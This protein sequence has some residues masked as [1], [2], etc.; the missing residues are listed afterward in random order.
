M[1]ARTGDS[2]SVT[3]ASDPTGRQ[4]RVLRVPARK[5]R[6]PSCC[7]RTDIWCSVFSQRT[8]GRSSM[9]AGR[10]PASA[11]PVPVENPTRPVAS[12]YGTSCGLGS[13]PQSRASIQ[14]G[15]APSRANVAL[16]TPMEAARGLGD[17]GT[18]VAEVAT[19]PGGRS[20]GGATYSASTRW[21]PATVSTSTW[22]RRSRRIEPIRHHQR[23]C[24]CVEPPGRR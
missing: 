13:V 16:S 12:A 2:R 9:Q 21:S 23:L 11:Q 5:V 24:R 17:K 15:A 7:K 4:S 18:D 3:R 14:R 1:R 22:S 20:G 10:D 19:P 6:R 8:S